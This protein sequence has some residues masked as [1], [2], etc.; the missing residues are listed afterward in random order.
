MS[1]LLLAIT[2]IEQ[3]NLVVSFECL[4]FHLILCSPPLNAWATVAGVE[5]CPFENLEIEAASET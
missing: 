5:L 3:V 2:D 1:L 4:A